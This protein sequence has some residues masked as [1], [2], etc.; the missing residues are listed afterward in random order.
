MFRKRESE[1]CKGIG[2]A[3]MIFHH[4]FYKAENYQDFVI[5]FAPF[6]EERI[7]FYALL[8]KVCVAI[9]VFISGYGITASYYKKFAD[10][11]PSVGEIKDFIWKRIWK[12]LTLYWFAFLLTCLCQPLGRTITEAYGGELKSKIVYFLLDFF[13]LSYLFGT[14]TLNPTWWYISLALLIILA[15]PWILKLFRKAGILTTICLSMGILFL[16]NASNANTFY[17][18]PVLLGAGCQEGR[19]FERLDEFC[20]KKRWGKAI[21][22]ISETVL[23]L[24]MISIRTMCF[25]GKHSGNMFLIHNQIYSYYFVGLIYGC[26]NWIACFVMLVGVSLVVSI[27]MEKIKEWTQYNRWMERIGQKTGKTIFY[28]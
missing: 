9:F 2:I 5:S 22:I 11:E 21:K 28:I 23:L 19:V 13:G 1:F 14:P 20:K 12:L 7:N 27:G 26:G 24:F 18:F 17:L 6:S 25:L 4:L 16:L 10:W 3:M 15:V 8:C